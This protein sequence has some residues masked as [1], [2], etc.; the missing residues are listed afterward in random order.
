[1]EGGRGAQDVED[2]SC[3]QPSQ[4]W[5]PCLQITSDYLSHT[6]CCFVLVT[7]YFSFGTGLQFSVITVFGVF[8]TLFWRPC[9]DAP[10]SGK[11]GRK[12]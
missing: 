6:L 12:L 1:M 2:S 10:Y 7:I 9:L 3:F 11:A 8:G 5:P 4:S